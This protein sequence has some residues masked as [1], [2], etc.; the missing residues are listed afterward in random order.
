MKTVLSHLVAII[1]LYQ[2]RGFKPGTLLTDIEFCSLEQEL[3]SHGVRLNYISEKKHVVEAE[4]YIRVA[5]ECVR[6]MLTAT[7]FQI[8]LLIILREAVLA[9]PGPLNKLIEP[10]GI[11]MTLS[12]SNIV[13]G[14]T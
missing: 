5:K 1:R 10:N 9:V 3:L 13:T 14:E 6:S 12:S 8:Y 2:R 7:S 11:S 4:C